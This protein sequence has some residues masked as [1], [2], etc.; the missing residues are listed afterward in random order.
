[1]R[2]VSGQ[3]GEP[4]RYKAA[5]EARYN[6]LTEKWKQVEIVLTPLHLSLYSFSVKIITYF[7]DLI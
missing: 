4:T 7:W 6:L 1:M 2:T 3:F 5:T